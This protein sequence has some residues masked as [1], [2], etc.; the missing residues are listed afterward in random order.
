MAS[1]SEKQ[2]IDLVW[3]YI[4]D[5]PRMHDYLAWP[6]ANAHVEFLVTNN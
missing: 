3:P 2:V 1:L 6:M 4:H 5:K